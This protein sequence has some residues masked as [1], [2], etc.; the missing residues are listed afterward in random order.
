MAYNSKKI[1]VLI[2]YHN[3]RGLE[4]IQAWCWLPL[5]YPST[6]IKLDMLV[7][8]HILTLFWRSCNP[9]VKAISSTQITHMESFHNIMNEMMVP[10]KWTTSTLDQICFQA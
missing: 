2:F 7:S 1:C 5:E 6:Y 3:S 8:M 10:K 4:E 9:H